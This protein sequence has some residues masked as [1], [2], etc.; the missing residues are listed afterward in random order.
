MKRILSILLFLFCDNAKG[1]IVYFGQD[2][3]K[4]IK[5]FK[6]YM[7]EEGNSDV[8][9]EARVFKRLWQDNQFNEP[10]MM[11]IIRNANLMIVMTNLKRE[12]Q[13]LAYTRIL[14]FSRKKMTA[15][16]FEQ[17]H[18]MFEKVMVT[19]VENLK[20]FLDFSIN[21]L[22]EKKLFNSDGRKWQVSLDEYEL[23]YTQVPVIK[24]KTMDLMCF[25][26]G[27]TILIQSTSGTYYPY[28]KK[29]E[30]HEGRID[31]RRTG[32]DPDAVYAKLKKYTIS[33]TK[34]E[35]KADTVTYYN[36][37]FF[38]TPLIGSFEDK[39]NVQSEGVRSQFP[40]FNSFDRGIY[41]K[42]LVKGVD[43][44][45]G[46]YHRGGQIIGGGSD[47]AR[48][49][50]DFW[51]NKKLEGRV[52]AKNFF[53]NDERIATDK[54]VMSL[55]LR[56]S[57][58][59]IDSIYHPQVDFNFNIADRKFTV[60]RGSEGITQ[61]PY[62]S[63]YHKT[64][65][66]VDILIWQMDVPRF[67]LKMINTD[68]P[69]TFE[70]G[71]FFKVNRYEQ[72]QGLLDYNPIEQLTY[73]CRD[74]AKK[75]INNPGVF[76]LQEYCDLLKNK[77]EYV[78]P[79]ILL[80]N[81][82]GFLIY[83]PLKEQIQ[84]NKKLFEYYNAHMGLVD[85]DVIRLESLIKGRSNAVINLINNDLLIEGC[86]GLQFSDSQSVFTIA[87]EQQLYLQK[88]R[89][90][91]FSG[92][93]HAG[94]FDFYG[95]SFLFNYDGFL[96]KMDNVD[97]M[98][99]NC[100]SREDPQKFVLVKT[101]LQNIYG[102]LF[103]DKENNKNG[104]KEYPEYPRFVSDR[105]AMVYYDRP[106]TFGGVYN[107][108]EFFFKTDPFEINSLDKFKLEDIKLAGLFSSGGIIP[109]IHD[110]L[111]VQKD[112][113]L[114]FIRPTLAEG[115]PMYG[116][117]G[118]NIGT[119]SLSNEGF[120]GSGKLEYLSS[121]GHSSRFVM[122][123]DSTNGNFEDYTI[124]RT[125]KVPDV[126]GEN[127]WLH[128]EPKNDKMF[129]THIITPFDMMK[130]KA[131]MFGTVVLEPTGCGGF[132]QM[133][134]E[135]AIL[136]SDWFVFN[137][138]ITTAEVSA[139][140]IHS[141]LDST[142]T[143]FRSNYLT[144]KVNFDGRFGDFKTNVP[145]MHTEFP[146]NK[147]KCNFNDFHWDMGKQSVDL[148][149]PGGLLSEDPAFESTKFNQDG[150]RFQAGKA[151]YDLKNYLLD[152][153]LVPFIP[154]VDA[155]VIPDKGHVVIDPDAD[156]RV[157][158]N[159]IVICDSVSE[160]HKIFNCTMK[161]LGKFKMEGDGYYDYVQ[162]N[163]KQLI[164]FDQVSDNKGG[165]AI[166]VSHV[167]DSTRFFVGDRFQFKGNTNLTSTQKYLEFDGYIKPI[168]E[169][170]IRTSWYRNTQ[171]I[172]PDSVILV[173]SHPLNESKVQIYAGMMLARDSTHVYPIFSG[174]KYTYSDDEILPIHGALYYDK[175][176]GK[177]IMGDSGKLFHNAITGNY[178]E[179]NE[180]E[181]I[182]YAEGKLNL[183][184]NLGDIKIT[185]AGN[186][187]SGIGDT[188]F[189]DFS[190]VALFDIPLPKSALNVMSDSLFEGSEK[191]KATKLYGEVFRKGMAEM[192]D[193]PKKF[194]RFE[195]RLKEDGK[196]TMNDELEKTFFFTD[197]KMTWHTRN[198][199]FTGEGE[200]GL[201]AVGKKQ[202]GKNV[203]VKIAINKNKAGDA[204]YMLIRNKRGG[205]YFFIY[206]KGTLGLLSSDNTF[207]ELADKDA[208]KVKAENT[209]IRAASIKQKQRFDRDFESWK[210]D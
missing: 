99:F 157:L 200:M 11:A 160:Q 54:A 83:D 3:A 129:T 94:R 149:I 190:M 177:F 23:G 45:G 155:K 138:T 167:D 128:W 193:D 188:P 175:L 173:F 208:K 18:K 170:N 22:I 57:N 35:F 153:T 144:S 111:T 98:R 201:Q 169:L 9:D 10:Q 118:T 70:S 139:F 159:S 134:F 148:K 125:D 183:A 120:L 180:N 101:V 147:Y 119:I 21:L 189:I 6:T 202:L 77:K 43:Y 117:K 48:A 176:Y 87:T 76:T 103:I 142:L 127:I 67:D 197:M 210:V 184:L 92:K 84:L 136:S 73:W 49:K 7:D 15:E 116:G 199:V 80:L 158:R 14:N 209:R 109:D 42:N 31:W 55:Y 131:R 81:D 207:A 172:N 27:D 34:A 13:W 52:Y 53:I 95:S 12:D 60:M 113:S 105:G 82:K 50:L 140:E 108:N 24:F 143:I 165:R 181:K 93:V 37:D 90:M 205:W 26:Q 62:W 96:I 38:N 154:V 41:I 86:P 133:H 195:K 150:L 65:M 61:T 146:H 19:D 185:G 58:A 2:T 168:H 74:R 39:A 132:G 112:Y 196:F 123:L 56:D 187:R 206:N 4:F 72:I 156:M 51:Y 8:S 78:L 204:M 192:L 85:Y 64:E 145:G 115:Y 162:S 179:I 16:R 151:T 5:D 203:T 63:S 163:K 91:T 33:M 122:F 141:H 25:T 75:K 126:K 1:Q 178:F 182:A 88:N 40:R 30:G 164:H 191:A 66:K 194:E 114:G 89:N 124:A 46:F 135:H 104:K 71:N 198:R 121:I 69:A 36:L 152:I 59:T 102:T 97:S 28:T 106:E 166:A 137:P 186:V 100:P 47:T 68:A 161:V 130:G 29:W 174:R 110:T 79:Q 44:T 171:R 20:P 17:W 32:K 107:R